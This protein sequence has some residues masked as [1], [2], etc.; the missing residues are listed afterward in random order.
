MNMKERHRE[1]ESERMKP[2]GKN[3]KNAYILLL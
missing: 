2:R 1:R 3:T